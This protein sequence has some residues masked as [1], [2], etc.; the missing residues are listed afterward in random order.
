MKERKTDISKNL[1]NLAE[2]IQS[3]VQSSGLESKTV[4]DKKFPIVHVINPES[5][6]VLARYEITKTGVRGPDPQKYDDGKSLLGAAVANI[7]DMLSL[8]GLY[9]NPDT[10]MYDSQG[11]IITK[12]TF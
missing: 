7:A 3:W 4:P 5:Q 12:Q 6:Q 1:N 2:Q 9:F 10:E 8:S 11:T